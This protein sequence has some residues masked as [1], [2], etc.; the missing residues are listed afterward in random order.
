VIRN[1]GAALWTAATY[2]GV[3]LPLHRKTLRK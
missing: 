1:N 2:V 3:S